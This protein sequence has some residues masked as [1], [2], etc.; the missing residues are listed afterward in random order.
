MFKFCKQ[1]ST[2][3]DKNRREF[4]LNISSGVLVLAGLNKILTACSINNSGSDNIKKQNIVSPPGSKSLQHF[5]SACTACHLCVSSCPT[6]VIQPSFLEYGFFN[7]MQ[8]RMDFNN[9]FC[10]YECTVCGKLCPTGAI[11]PVT[12]EEKKLIQTGVA[13]FYKN[14]CIVVTKGTDCGA[15]SEHCPTKAVN[16]IPYSGLFLPEVNEEICIG[17][18]AC[19]FACQVTPVKAI[20]VK[21][22]MVHKKAKLP[23][24]EKKK[25]QVTDDFPF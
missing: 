17:C 23:V 22:N 3:P 6:Q 9:G 21:G 11:L 2:F 18:G 4:L 5:T 25:I 8:P 14:E 15:C 19:E 24:T 12:V 20:I 16:M 13:H 10:N 7:I 1:C